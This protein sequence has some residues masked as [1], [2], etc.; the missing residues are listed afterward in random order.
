MNLNDNYFNNLL[1]IEFMNISKSNKIILFLVAILGSNFNSFSQQRDTTNIIKDEVIVT[2]GMVPISIS[3][4][5]RSVYVIRQEDIQN[6]PVQNLQDLL[7][8][9]PGLDLRAR[10]LEGVQA[11]VSLRGG[12]FEQTLILLDGVKLN[13]P[14]TGHHNMN[15]PVNMNDIER[16][17]ILKGPASSIYGPNAFAGVINFITKKAN[18]SELSANLSG[19]S[20]GFLNGGLSVH[21]PYVDSDNLLSI[22][23]TKSDGYTHNTNFDITTFY[24]KSYVPLN[25]GSANVAVGYTDKSFGANGFY[26]TQFPNQWE[27]TKT[28]LVSYWCRLFIR[29]I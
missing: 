29:A 18:N 28:L 14:Q 13:D 20:F 7:S 21:V 23:K 5:P 27:E 10:G 22:S 4:V 11:D 17:E 24:Y 3:E 16:V 1:A 26:T 25:S 2:A 9:V 8:Y 6:S 19:G 12:S 15:L